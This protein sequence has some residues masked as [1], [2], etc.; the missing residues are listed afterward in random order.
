MHQTG[1]RTR[2]ARQLRTRTTGAEDHLWTLVRG[3]RFEGLKFRRQAPVAGKIVDFLCPEL[4]LVIELDGGVHDL[5]SVE[6]AE[7]DLL[8]SEAGFLVLRSGNEAFLRNPNIL[9]DAIRLRASEMRNRPPHPSGSAA[10]LLPRG[11]KD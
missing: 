11:E 5:R 3:R 7:R 2:R 8:I 9:L 1:D 10:H 4:K 6:D